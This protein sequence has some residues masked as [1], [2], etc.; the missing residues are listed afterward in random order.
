MVCACPSRV[1][2]NEWSASRWA[3][4]GQSPAALGVPDCFGHLAVLG[5]PSG[6]AP[7]QPGYFFRQPPAELQLEE[8]RE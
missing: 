6:G 1:R 2:L 5:E 3:A 7:V 4:S 8:I